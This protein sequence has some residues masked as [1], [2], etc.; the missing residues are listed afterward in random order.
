M[1]AADVATGKR[2]AKAEMAAVLLRLEGEQ[3]DVLPTTTQAGD[4]G[5]LSDADLEALLGRDR[6][7]FVGEG[8]WAGGVCSV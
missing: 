6:V 4:E 3:I 7:A 1:P 5:I 2:A 8:E